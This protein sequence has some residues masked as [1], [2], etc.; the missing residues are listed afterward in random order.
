[1]SSWV[2]ALHEAFPTQQIMEMWKKLWNT[3]TLITKTTPTVEP[4]SEVEHVA[5]T[6]LTLCQDKSSDVP[7]VHLA[8]YVMTAEVLVLLTETLQYDKLG[9]AA[10]ESEY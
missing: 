4:N 1:M 9:E 6:L 3:F 10:E 5:S 2:P 7:D 8:F